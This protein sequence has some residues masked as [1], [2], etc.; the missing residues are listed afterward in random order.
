M[1]T[2]T[3]Y[4][5]PK[6]L[7]R[8]RT[9]TRDRKGN[10]LKFARQVDPSAND[11]ADFLAMAL[12]HRPDVPFDGPLKVNCYFYFPRPK[13]HFGS[14]GGKPYLKPTAPTY[15]T[16][17]PDT[18]NLIKFVADGLNGIFWCDD[19]LLC[20]VFAQK[21]YDERPRTIVQIVPIQL[22]PGGAEYD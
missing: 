6:A 7:K 1:I 11:K 9:Y 2:F 22:T 18:D 12:Q 13:S 17:R 10:A 3:V 14:K 16:G 4:G 15:H 20:E 19:S 5:T 8:H 21:K